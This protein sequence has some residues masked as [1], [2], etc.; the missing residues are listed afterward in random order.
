MSCCGCSGV[1]GGPSPSS[2]SNIL[3]SVVYKTPA[4]S[5]RCVS[6]APRRGVRYSLPLNSARTRT[7]KSDWGIYLYISI[8]DPSARPQT[9][10]LEFQSVSM[11]DSR[12]SKAPGFQDSRIQ[13]FQISEFQDFNIPG[14][15]DSRIPEL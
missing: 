9:K 7:D 2:H 11:P 1:K 10:I 3:F 12:D 6:P 14:S 8:Y 15:Q 13:R 4:G 5:R